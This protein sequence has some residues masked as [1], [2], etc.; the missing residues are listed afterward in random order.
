[1]YKI[2]N[3]NILNV[4]IFVC[5]FILTSRVIPI[6]DTPMS[7]YYIALFVIFFIVVL[8][9]I[10]F[11]GRVNINTLF[12]LFVVFASILLNEIPSKFSPYARYLAFLVMIITFGPFIK[13]KSLYAFNK[14]IIDYFI[15]LYFVIVLLSVPLI[16]SDLYFKGI[17]NQ[18]MVLAPITSICIIWLV[19]Y[20]WILL[21]NSKLIKKL[22]YLLLLSICIITLIATASR[23]A[24]VACLISLLFYLFSTSK[25]LGK[26]L[27]YFFIFAVIIGLS[28]PLWK[29]QMRGIIIKMEIQENMEG[30]NSR[31]N[32][33]KSR[34]EEFKSSPLIGIGFSRVF[35]NSAGYRSS[36]DSVELGSAWLGLM[37]QTGILGLLCF[38]S[39]FISIFT[40]LWKIK[41]NDSSRLFLLTLIIFFSCHMIFEG[42]ILAAGSILSV[43][44]WLALGLSYNY[45]TFNNK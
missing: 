27:Q 24:I 19:S 10:K 29:G 20:T 5:A 40:K 12:Y 35:E 1:M 17:T 2:I 25:N 39:M 16:G 23:S 26:F 41:N 3:N 44:F 38:L 30:D 34:I 32:M 7:L 15:F 13:S 14:R 37:S 33:W 42:Y 28:Y 9:L 21:R 45:V 6:L 36:I 8:Y 18:S 4:T 22:F 31:T 11:G 43:F